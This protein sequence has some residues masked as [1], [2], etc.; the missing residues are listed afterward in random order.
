M[1]KAQRAHLIIMVMPGERKT[2]M[3]SSCGLDCFKCEG[4]LATQAND[5]NK[6]TVQ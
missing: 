3:I 5:G 1:G 6:R 4:Y 2:K